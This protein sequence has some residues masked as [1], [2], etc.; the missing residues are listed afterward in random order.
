LL[1]APPWSGPTRFSKHHLA[2]HLAQARGQV[3]YIE[4]PLT[5]VGLRRG[6][7]FLH[8]LAHTLQPARKVAERLWVRRHFVPIPYHAATAW[9]SSRRANRLAQ[10]LLA[11]ILQR[12][13]RQIGFMRQPVVIAG[14]P[15]VVDLL[16]WLPRRALIYHCADDYASVRGFPRSLPELE[17]DLCR[18]ADLVIT[19]SATL[20]ADRQKFNPN[21]H[22]VPN[23]ADV[24]H[25]GKAAMPADEL[26][27]IQRPVVGFVGGLSE[28]VD[29]RLIAD[30][31]TA[32]P[33]VSFVLV[34]PVG[35]DVSPLQHLPNVHLLG[36]RHYADLPNYLAAMDVGLIPFKQD[37]VTFH[38]DPIKAYEYLA[39]GV[40]VVA[41][42]L[43]A[44]RRL[45]HVLRLAH[46]AQSFLSEIDAALSATRAS[47]F[48]QRQAEAARHSWASRFGLVD[49]L[50]DQTLN[51]CAR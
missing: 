16:P 51:R 35:V 4:A 40:P 28:W 26:T 31:A 19:T 10:R 14:L 21:T 6:R 50:F 25:F 39:A 18:Q 17:A 13:L 42:D 47:G 49:A 46:D 2:Q 24:E 41:T 30:L 11:P 32:R 33:G 45:E 44:L 29:I 43:P 7:G 5:P 37:R 22:W 48:A 34:G 12:D 36:P 20:C 15:H 9:T 27:R 3:L 1:Y 23:G 38:A 8:E